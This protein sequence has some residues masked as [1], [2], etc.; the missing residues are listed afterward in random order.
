MQDRPRAGKK[1][2]YGKATNK[3][4]LALL[5][6]PPPQGYA[7]WTG[8]LLAKAL[9][10]VDVQYVWRFLREH[11]IDLAARKSWCESNDPSFV[12]K[13]ADVVGL[14]VDPPVKAIVLCVD[15]KPSIQALERAQGYLKLPNSRLTADRVESRNLAASIDLNGRKLAAVA[16]SSGAEYLD[17]MHLPYTKYKDLP[18]A[19]DSL[20]DGQ[21][22]VVVNSVGALQYFVAKRYAKV[23]EVLQGLLAPA[24]MAI[25]LPEHSPI[26]KPIDRALIKITNGPEWRTLE[27][28]FLVR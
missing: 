13:A 9:G 20:A 8:P 10:D 22:N 6:K 3:R 14:Y 4:I 19:L 23:I 16:H 2:I 27:E 18:E 25:A 12:A 1:P 7:R 5:D 17:Q 28:R 26:K 11:T 24:Y 21:S 15:E